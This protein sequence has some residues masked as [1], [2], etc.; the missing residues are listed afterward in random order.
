VLL[1]PVGAA[2]LL[3]PEADVAVARAAAELGLPYV[4]SSQ[5]CASMERCAAVMGDAPR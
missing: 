1:G 4:F 2:E 5:A 3:H